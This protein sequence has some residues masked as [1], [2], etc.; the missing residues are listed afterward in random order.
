MTQSLQGRTALVTGASRGIGREIAVDLARHGAF[1]FCV[2]TRE[3]GCDETVAACG[4]QGGEAVGLACDVS[5]EA[6][7][8]A[9]VKAVRESGRTLEILVNNAGI[10][11][12]GSFLRMSTDDFDA[13]QNVNLRGTFFVC[14]AFARLLSKAEDGRIINIGSVVGQMGNPGQAN[15]AASKA[16]VVGMTK[17]LAKELAGRQVTC[18]VVA[19]GYI[20]TDM[21]SELP[22]DVREWL[23]G[24]IP[25]HRIGTAEEVAAAVTFLAAPAA[26]YITGQVLVVDGGMC[27]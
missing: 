15:Y 20:Q 25:L 12:D 2:S 26:R 24:S 10:T 5:D 21:T 13:V 9:L 6:S 18:N 22:D 23:L 7:V 1:V 27:I 3:G 14:R 19:P 4:E 11:R 16:A 17:S 8:D